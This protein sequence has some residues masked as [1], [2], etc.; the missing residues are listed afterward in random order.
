MVPYQINKNN[1]K[2]YSIGA[3]APTLPQE[4]NVKPSKATLLFYEIITDI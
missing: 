3:N 1:Q 4:A 2:P